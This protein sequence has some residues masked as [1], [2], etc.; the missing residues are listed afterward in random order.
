MLCFVKDK[1]GQA[2]ELAAVVQGW[3]TC[4]KGEEIWRSSKQQAVTGNGWHQASGAVHYQLCRGPC[5]GAARPSSWLQATRHQTAAIITR[6]GEGVRQLQGVAERHQPETSWR[7]FILFTVATVDAVHRVSQANDGP[8]LDL[9]EE[10]HSDIQVSLFTSTKCVVMCLFA[11]YCMK[12]WQIFE[13]NFL[14]I[15]IDLVSWISGLRSVDSSNYSLPRLN[16]R[17]RERA[18]SYTGPA[19]WNQLPESICQLQTTSN[20]NS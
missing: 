9:S 4:T 14:I 15:W 13:W 11:G 18:F 20:I 10:Q 2:F 16:T 7:K 5:S 17:V 3:R 12:N 19:A 6:Q 8:V 1:P